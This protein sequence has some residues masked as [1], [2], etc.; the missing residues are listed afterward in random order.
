MY[1]DGCGS[2]RTPQIDSEMMASL[3]FLGAK[4]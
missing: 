2:E 4:P 1:I 3:S